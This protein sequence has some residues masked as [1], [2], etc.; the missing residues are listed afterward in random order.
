MVRL[1]H[2][3]RVGSGSPRAY[4]VAVGIDSSATT[5]S[6]TTA[7]CLV[8]RGTEEGFEA[9][10]QEPAFA[11]LTN[12]PVT[13]RLFTSSTRLGDRIGAVVTLA[14]DEISALPP[15]RTVLRFGKGGV[16]SIPVHLVVRLTTVG[17][18]ELW[19]QSQDSEHRWRLQFDLRADAAPAPPM[20]ALEETVDQ[21]AVAAAREVIRNTFG[22]GGRP[23][24]APPEALRKTLE[25]TLSVSR[26]R[27]PTPLIRQLADE[28]LENQAGRS[29][30]PEHE[31]RWLNLLG[32]CLRPG[33][34]DPGDELRMQEVWRLY[35]RGLA[36]PKEPQCRSEWWIFLRRVAGGLAAAKQTQIYRQ[37][38]PYLQSGRASKQKPSPMF[39]K[40]LKPGEDVEAWMTLASLEW[41]PGEA[42]VEIGRRLLQQWRKKPPT[43]REHWAL[44][45]LG[46]RRMMYATA[47][48]VI[49]GLEAAAWVET[50]A[51]MNLEP[52]EHIAHCLVLLAQYTGDRGRD[53][54]DTMREQVADWLARLPDPER[55]REL[56]LNP[57]SILHA[58]EQDW[59]LGDAL[60]TGLVL[61]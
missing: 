25:Q 41:L 18:L 33:F 24:P 42:K 21:A 37:A 39:P 52:S 54:P 43:P 26:D 44:S 55:F 53:I 10:I 23:Q 3:V 38:W 51:G 58:Q 50:L 2:G 27:W 56:L 15:I 12:Q 57:E 48:R 31:K 60:P 46:S 35:L 47:D 40:H 17:T 9:N 13:F 34:G 7:V 61:A 49:P 5:G 45:R 16:K 11:A 19:C 30:S 32:F 22:S 59:M 28:L 20:A 1:G 14:E 4:Y 36:F 8:P 29:R 6:T